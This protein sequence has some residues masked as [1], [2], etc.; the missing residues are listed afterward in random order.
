MSRVDYL[1]LHRLQAKIFNE[2]LNIYR[3]IE[4]QHKGREGKKLEDTLC[5][6]LRDFLPDRYG[7]VTGKLVDLD[8]NSSRQSDII[9]YDQLFNP[10]LL[11]EDK[12]DKYVPI[13][14]ARCV[15]EVKARIN[16]NSLKSA[17]QNLESIRSLKRAYQVALAGIVHHANFLVP[18]INFYIFAFDS[19][20]QNVDTLLSLLQR[21]LKSIQAA[22]DS[23]YLAFFPNLISINGFG[24]AS[25]AQQS[26]KLEHQGQDQI[27][28]DPQ[29]SSF[30]KENLMLSFLK[31]GEDS[32]FYFLI[33]LLEE[34]DSIPPTKARFLH[35]LFVENQGEI[36]VKT[37]TKYKFPQT[38]I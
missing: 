34:A 9:V 35:L 24:N 14:A 11:F 31:N 29:V 13:E 32:L 30:G 4:N 19:Y 17:L 25:L 7:V 3:L 33:K 26:T 10:K 6:L 21:Q 12:L 28:F 23:N 22:K 36:I 27:Y 2:K 16:N 18:P 20:T 5:N 15:I 37:G 1:K 8:G 38:S